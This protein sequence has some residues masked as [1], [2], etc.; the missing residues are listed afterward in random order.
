MR[1]NSEAAST[2][3]L[4]RRGQAEPFVSHPRWRAAITDLTWQGDGSLWDG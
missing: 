2:Y 3:D 1:V 4:L